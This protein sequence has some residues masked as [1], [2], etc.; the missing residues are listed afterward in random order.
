MKLGIQLNTTIYKYWQMVFF[1]C[2]IYNNLQIALLSGIQDKPGSLSLEN[3]M[4][5]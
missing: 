5:N 2:Y 1:F 4:I 3:V